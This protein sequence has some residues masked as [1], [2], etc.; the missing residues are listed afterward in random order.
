[1]IA[2]GDDPRVKA[3]IMNMP[4]VSGA[5]DMAGF[6][7]G[8]LDR[9][10]QRRQAGTAS[11]FPE[12]EYVQLWPDSADMDVA[13]CRW[14]NRVTLRSAYNIARTECQEHLA[15]VEV[16]TLYLYGDRDLF[17]TA[18]QHR[19][20]FARLPSGEFTVAPDAGLSVRE[21]FA[22]DARLMIEFI[23]RVLPRR[24]AAT[25]KT[26]HEPARRPAAA[27]ARGWHVPRD[28]HLRST[29]AGRNPGRRKKEGP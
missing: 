2:A 4:F 7:P 23:K 24:R 20:T 13:G 3:V 25:G 26:G 15:K 8:A 9:A 14:E 12:P 6:P 22:A 11:G 18:D 21:M 1:M 17:M 16:P 5:F 10:W 27:T 29:P 28:H 19:D